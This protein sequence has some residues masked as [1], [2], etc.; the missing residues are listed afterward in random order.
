LLILSQSANE[1]NALAFGPGT[2][3]YSCV[4]SVYRFSVAGQKQQDEYA[5]APSQA[6][7]ALLRI[8]IV[9]RAGDR[10]AAVRR[11]LCVTRL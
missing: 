3:A 11:A 1:P 9:D 7:T 4:G 10:G 8:R 2:P 6:A 5:A